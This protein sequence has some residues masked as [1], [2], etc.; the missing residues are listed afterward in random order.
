MR[1]QDLHVDVTVHLAG[2]GGPQPGEC[3]DWD[4]RC[5]PGND[6]HGTKP[7]GCFDVGGVLISGLPCTPALPPGPALVQTESADY[8]Q[9]PPVIP[10]DGGIRLPGNQQYPPGAA[11]FPLG[12]RLRLQPCNRHLAPTGAGTG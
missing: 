6:D 1:S 12:L 5:G 4:H 10:D 3:V 8:S 2:Q 9:P 11:E 7:W